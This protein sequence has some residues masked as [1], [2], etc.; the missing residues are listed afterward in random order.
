MPVLHEHC[1][2]DGRATGLSVGPILVVLYLTALAVGATSLF[3]TLSGW[4]L[5]SLYGLM[6]CV[7]VLLPLL[8][9]AKPMFS[10]YA[11][12]I[13]LPLQQILLCIAYTNNPDWAYPMK[14]I[15]AW[16]DLCLI[17]V[18]TKAWLGSQRRPAS[19]GRWQTWTLIYLALMFLLALQ[20]R[21]PFM[22]VAA[23][24]RFSIVPFLF[25][26]A[27]FYVV[28]SAEQAK[29]LLT[30]LWCVVAGV[31][32]FG[33]F[34]LAFL[35]ET[36]F[37][38]YIDI[39]GFK[40]AVH[41]AGANPH[42]GSYLY[43]PGFLGRRRMVSV[44]L[45]STGTAHYLTFA[46]CLFLACQHAG[47]AFK[48]ELLRLGF[49]G[50]MVLGILLTRS[51]L[52]MG[53]AC[54]IGMYYTAAG[55]LRR[56]LGYGVLGFLAVALLFVWFRSAIGEVV[57]STWLMR[58]PSTVKHVGAIV[59]APLAILGKGLGC[60]ANVFGD[61]DVGGDRVSEGIYNRM[62][63]ETGLVGFSLFI[64]AYGAIVLNALRASRLP[65]VDDGRRLAKAIGSMG[66]VYG[67]VMVP[68]IFITVNLF[69]AVSHGCFWFVTG[70]GLSLHGKIMS[71]RGAGLAHGNG[72]G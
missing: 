6:P 25:L 28:E 57:S 18:L 29:R 9:L 54:L 65:P 30:V 4:P 53:V 40:S 20:M 14:W 7:F 19:H 42:V 41:G 60:G 64:I 21:F 35:H 32:A 51:R 72:G 63:S 13:F 3:T 61:D 2:Y 49:V 8:A 15:L 33:I 22:A 48:N 5:S 31:V 17:F 34:E 45:G 1:S 66:A 52:G 67:M 46:L 11:F 23:S 55:R 12:A 10:A 24:L 68:S 59:D 58:D 26:C 69:S 50:L 16:K 71:T 27:G 70:V 56:K 39:G 47:V 38:D 62:V 43:A 44:F 36:F 37:T